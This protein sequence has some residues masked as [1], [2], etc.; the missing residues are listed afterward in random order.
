M[1]LK[2][3][4][5]TTAGNKFRAR[6]SPKYLLIAAACWHLTLTILIYAC[7]HFKLFPKLFDINGIGILFAADCVGYRNEAISLI[8]TLTHN[9]VLAW[10]TASSKVLVNPFHLKLYSLSFAVFGPLF[11][12]NILSAEPLNLLYY[13]LILYLIY[14]LGREAFNQ[15]VG[16]V[17]ASLVALWPS[18]LLHTTQLFRDP[19]FIV[20][21]L[22]LVLACARLLAKDYSWPKNLVIAIS[23]AAAA[24]LLWFLRREMWEVMLAT[25][26]LGASL[27]IIKQLLER[28]SIAPN[29][30]GS[31]LL[32][33]WVMCLPQTGKIVALYDGTANQS[34]REG[35]IIMEAAIAPSFDEANSSIIEKKPPTPGSSVPSRIA[36][37]RQGFI[38]DYPDAKSNVDTDVQFVSLTSV[39][40]YLPRAAM[41][42]FFAPFPDMWFAAG[43][44]V[45]LRGRLLSGL[46][47]TLMYAIS[48]AAL[49]G[50]WRK[51]RSLIVWLLLLVAATGL[52]AL[53]LVVVNIAALYR[54]RYVFW[55]LLIILGA[56]GLVQYLSHINGKDTAN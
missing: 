10:L 30:A 5:S 45:G 29:I 3:S 11:G 27:L 13:L 35:A 26:L 51:R 47:T 55:M 24:C 9:G 18:F 12:D 54:M 25:A 22:T 33:I 32:L 28:R 43:D 49:Y 31:L 53:G 15:R 8:N 14:T 52:T 6:A 34:P 21:M 44:Q 1:Q 42:G 46:E 17:A 19:L 16:L 36:R 20:A 56:N 7:G 39:I 40:E 50:V 4:Q 38:T 23:G 41:I 2:S 37:L 48:F